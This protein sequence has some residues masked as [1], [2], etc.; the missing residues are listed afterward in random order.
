MGINEQRN[1]ASYTYNPVTRWLHHERWILIVVA[2]ALLAVIAYRTLNPQT[3]IAGDR[4]P[5]YLRV[6]GD[7]ASL[8]D[9]LESIRDRELAKKND[10]GVGAVDAA[11][12]KMSLFLVYDYMFVMELREESSFFSGYPPREQELIRALNRLGGRI[13]RI[14]LRLHESAGNPEVPMDFAAMRADLAQARSIYETERDARL[15]RRRSL[16]RPGREPRMSPRRSRAATRGTP[17][18]FSPRPTSGTARRMPG[19][20]P[21]S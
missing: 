11:Q 15:A 4:L 20:S 19:A 16:L 6:L 2:V 21:S 12:P 17:A 10:G 18:S 9:N 5:K 1:D 8:V 7:F 3:H 14:V 13:D